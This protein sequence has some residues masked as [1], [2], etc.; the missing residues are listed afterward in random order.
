MEP[1]SASSHKLITTRRRGVIALC[2]ASFFLANR[3]WHPWLSNRFPH[4]DRIRF[5]SWHAVVHHWYFA[6]VEVWESVLFIW[7]LISAIRELR[8]SER[9]YFCAWLIAALLSVGRDFFPFDWNSAASHLAVF[10]E[11]AMI[12]AAAFVL[13]DIVSKESRRDP[14]QPAEPA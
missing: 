1:D 4:T 6:S 5:D 10:L 11:C 2:V 13:R 8:G 7:F 9:T 12:V 3:I 14:A